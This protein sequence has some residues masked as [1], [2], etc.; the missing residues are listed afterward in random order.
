MPIYP[1]MPFALDMNLGGAY[2]DAM[3]LLGP[4]DWAVFLDH[5]AMWTTRLWFSQIEEAI[6]F[7]PTAGAFT[8]KTN[9]I[10]SPWQKSGNADDHDVASNRRWGMAQTKHRTLLDVTETN[11]MG[12]V[13]IVISRRAWEAAGGF[14]PGMMCVD[15]MMH[16]ALRRAGLRVYCIEGL[17]VYHWRRA[18]GDGPPENAPRAEGC[19]CRGPEVSPQRQL[20]LP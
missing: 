5:D 1:M 6:H 16:F 14:V 9:R 11:G 20:Q 8:C 18:F 3:R 15:H 4:E 7:Q 2:N 13:V 19:P 17:Y 12:G 10:A